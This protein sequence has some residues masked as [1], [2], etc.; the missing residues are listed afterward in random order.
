MD[1]FISKVYKHAEH[2]KN[3]A[4]D[5]RTEED[6]K[7]ALILTLFDILGFS[8]SNP[9]K[10][11]AEYQAI[12]K[13][14]KDVVKRVDYALFQNKKVVMFIEAKPYGE[15][16]SN[17]EDQL[18]IY[19]NSTPDVRFAA[20]TNGG[21][22]RFFTDLKEP[23]MMDESPFLTIDFARLD[24]AQICK[25][26]DFRHDKFEPDHLK[27]LA[28]ESVYLNLFSEVI[29]RNLK[30]PSLDFVKYVATCAD[31]GKHKQSNFFEGLIPI[32]TQA[33]KNAI[34]EI[35]AAGLA[36]KPEPEPKKEDI[37]ADDQNADI[38]DQENPKIIT[39]AAERRLFELVKE[40]LP[41][42]AGDLT[43]KD[44]EYYCSILYGEKVTKW[45]VRYR[46][47]GKPA[48]EFPMELNDQQRGAIVYAGLE[49]TG[50]DSDRVKISTP[51]D[52][53]RLS[54][55]LRDALKYVK[56]D[57]NFKKGK[58]KKDEME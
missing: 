18:R 54:G 53:M 13:G 27:E 11:K 51:E 38:V 55:P 1:E 52:I 58:N 49:I 10:V 50:K 15:E 31:I 9:N 28:E 17:H 3:M 30:D 25:L 47:A 24:E 37:P 43:L 8:P 40:L 21:E 19:F 35:T 39:S 32:V 22:W 48:I 20:I 33:I 12:F 6:T 56:N 16:L 46:T 57:E 2:V 29:R 41:A 44:T 34:A 36:S 4:R 45:V 5:C 26:A 14:G 23:N 42:V 7:Q